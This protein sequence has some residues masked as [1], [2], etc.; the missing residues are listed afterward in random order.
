MCIPKGSK[1]KEA[2]EMYINFLCEPEVAAANAD[3]I[4]YATPNTAA[5]ELLD[6]EVT[7][8]PVAYPPEEVMEKAEAFGT[9]PRDASLL[10]DKLWTDLLSSDE[11]YSRMLVPILLFS[12]LLLSVG[13]NVYRMINKRKRQR[14]YF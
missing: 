2:A 14:F 8:D 11:N 12:A 7:G 6:E 3:Y 5:L 10:M 9:L 4:G 1:Q 13:I